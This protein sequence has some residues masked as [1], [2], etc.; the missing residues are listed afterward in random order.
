MLNVADSALHSRQILA[1]DGCSIERGQTLLPCLLIFESYA[2]LIAP[3][4]C[5]FSDAAV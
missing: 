4:S 5:Q 3:I 1:S 2:L